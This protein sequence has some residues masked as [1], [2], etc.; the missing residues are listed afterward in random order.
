MIR[1]IR[2]IVLL[3]AMF[4]PVLAHAYEIKSGLVKKITVNAPMISN[5]G[6]IV[7]LDGV[8]SMCTIG[9]GGESGYF[10]KADIPD[11][12]A[13]FVSTLLTAQASG[14]PVIVF[15]IVGT[16]GCRIDQVQLAF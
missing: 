13:S 4:T 16:E 5:R 11:T 7:E 1:R 6:V 15:T 12:F 9:S 14:R 10:N 3:A 8:S 2:E